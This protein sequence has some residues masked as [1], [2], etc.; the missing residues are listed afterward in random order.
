MCFGGPG[1]RTEFDAPP[2]SLNPKSDDGIF[3]I[4]YY[5][6]GDPEAVQEQALKPQKNCLHRESC[7]VSYLSVI[8]VSNSFDGE[9]LEKSEIF[10]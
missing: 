10:T 4:Y 7:H 2:P 9:Y 8:R 6:P 3:F 1:D 5:F